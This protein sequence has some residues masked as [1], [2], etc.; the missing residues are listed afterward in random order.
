MKVLFCVESCQIWRSCGE[1]DWWK[2][3]FRHLALPLFRVLYLVKLSFTSEGA[4]KTFS[5][6]QKQGIPCQQTVL[7]EVLK[8]VLEGERN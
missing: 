7:Q 6:K 1:D 2:L 8:D 5:G 3:L 4:I